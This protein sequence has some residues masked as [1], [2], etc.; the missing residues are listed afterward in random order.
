MGSLF[1]FVFLLSFHLISLIFLSV[2]LFIVGVKISVCKNTWKFQQKRISRVDCMSTF[3]LNMSFS[4]M[5][6]HFTFHR[7]WINEFRQSIIIILT[8]KEE[9]KFVI[10]INNCIVFSHQFHLNLIIFVLKNIFPIWSVK[11]V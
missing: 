6:L 5:F 8:E 2:L 11:Y 10:E 4:K 7:M 1:S 3:N 9:M